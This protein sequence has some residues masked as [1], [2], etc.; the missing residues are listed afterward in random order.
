[1]ARPRIGLALGSGAARGWAHLGVIAAL[2]RAGIAPDIVCG[3]S[4]GALVGAAYVTGR[5]AALREF[6]ESVTWRQIVAMLDV[7]LAGGGLISGQRIVALLRRLG[8]AGAIEDCAKPFV[9]IATDLETGREIWL[10]DGP[11]DEAVRASISVP[12]ILSPA[13]HGDRWLVDGG[14]V[15]PVPVSAC[16]ALGADLVIAVNLNADLLERFAGDRRGPA[17]GGAVRPSP[18]FIQR[19]LDQMPATLRQQA[20]AIAPKLLREGPGK[21]GYFDVLM[22]SLTIMEDLI[23]RARL[24]GEPPHVLLSPRL[25]DIGFLEYNRAAETIAEGDACMEQALPAL[26]RYLA[27]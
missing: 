3:C 10:R 11:I 16:R 14:V 7:E 6:A 27:L 25:H 15:N 17:V 1:M 13:R 21:P 9:A 5:L 19:L 2:E 8:I 26:R 22:N 24:A 4:I 23:T 18:D 12:G 20:S